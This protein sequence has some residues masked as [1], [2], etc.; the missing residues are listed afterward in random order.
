[1]SLPK[2]VVRLAKEPGTTMSPRVVGE[3]MPGMPLPMWP[4]DW[5]KSA[6]SL[7]LL[8]PGI[9]QWVLRRRKDRVGDISVSSSLAS[10]LSGGFSSPDRAVVGWTPSALRSLAAWILP[11]G[12]V[13]GERGAG[14]A[15]GLRGRPRGFAVPRLAGNLAGDGLR[16]GARIGLR[17][18]LRVGLGDGL[19]SACLTGTV[20]VRRVGAFEGPR[21]TKLRGLAGTLRDREAGREATTAGRDDGGLPAC[22]A[23]TSVVLEGVTEDLALGLGL[24]PIP[25][26]GDAD[27]RGVEDLV[28]SGLAGGGAVWRGQGSGALR[29]RCWALAMAV[30]GG[31]AFAEVRVGGD[32]VPGG[33][34]KIVRDRRGGVWRARGLAGVREGIGGVSEV[35]AEALSPLGGS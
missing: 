10:A 25:D 5:D 14:F 30:A 27:R 23:L 2:E 6:E 26:G 34:F 1:M 21:V 3:E 12:E 7:E 20:G 17:V 8:R 16:A 22:G 19:R 32:K 4:N 28:T 33:R 15:V 24:R 31:A 9:P 29:D 13:A 11:S 18:G 35:R